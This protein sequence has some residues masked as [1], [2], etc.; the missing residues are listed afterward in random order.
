MKRFSALLL[1]CAI[2][3][4]ATACGGTEKETTP[5]VADTQDG[6]APSASTDTEVQETEPA[7]SD[8]LP[9]MDYDGKVYRIAS[10]EGYTDE[11]FTEELTGEVENDAVFNRNA[12]LS[13]RFNVSIQAI[14]MTGDCG[15]IYTALVQY[16]TAGDDFCDVAAQE[17][18]NFHM[19]TA[20][21]IYQNWNDTKYIHPDKPWWNQQINDGATFNGKLFGLT[22]SFSVTYMTSTTAIYVNSALLQNHGLTEADLYALV[23]DGGWTI[24]YLSTLVEGMYR[25][26]NGDGSRD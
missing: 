21:G 26:I 11:F 3:L 2:L 8:D 9:A 5:T 1:L 13:E 12:R 20:A 6:T 7:L 19:A 17:V 18:W 25:D 14:P 16:A 22:G 23:L 4:S 10:V 15:S 24:D